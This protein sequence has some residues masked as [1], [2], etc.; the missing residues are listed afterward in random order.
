MPD[1]TNIIILSA[2]LP[3]VIVVPVLLIV[4]VLVMRLVRGSVQN[5]EVLAHGVSAPA[6]IVRVW[7]TGTRLNN[8]PQ[9]GLVLQ[10]QPADKP[11]FQAEAKMFISY[12]LAAQLQPGKLVNVRYDPQNPGKVAVE[13]ATGM[14]AANLGGMNVPQFEEGLRVQDKYYEAIRSMGEAA[15][16]TIVSASETGVLVNGE[17]PLMK[18][19]LEVHPNNRP[20]FQAETQGVISQASKAKYQPGQTI[21]VK[22]NPNNLT[23]VALD[24]S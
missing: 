16:A 17:N 1:L 22:F 14:T 19:R 24:H 18:F 2:L 8:Q 23:Q 9:V 5:R 6:T 11:A 13:S 12:L 4:G 7:E 10:V 15:Q 21:W 20:L 3:I